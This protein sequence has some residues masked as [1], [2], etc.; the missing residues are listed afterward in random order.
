MVRSTMSKARYGMVHGCAS[1][2]STYVAKEG[3]LFMRPAQSFAGLR[4][5]GSP[6]KT[7]DNQRDL[8]SKPR[9]LPTRFKS[10]LDY[11]F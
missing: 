9:S 1:R 5:G 11:L 10:T 2:E 4:R 7:V 6:S 8:R 3:I